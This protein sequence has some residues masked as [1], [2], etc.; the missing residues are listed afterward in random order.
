MAD[1]KKINGHSLKDEEARNLLASKSNIGHI[2][3]ER[4]AIKEVEENVVLLVTN[5]DA[6]QYDIDNHNHNKLYA[7]KTE[8]NNTKVDVESLFV[9]IEELTARV[10]NLESIIN[11]QEPETPEDPE[12]EEPDNTKYVL[13]YKIDIGESQKNISEDLG[14]Y[15]PQL[16][17]EGAERY[18]LEGELTFVLTDGTT[19]TNRNIAPSRVSKVRITYGSYIIGIKFEDVKLTELIDIDTSNFTTLNSMFANCDLVQS[20][21]LDYWD[22]SKV[23]D[24]QNMFKG[25]TRL[26]ILNMGSWD[27]SKIENA[28]GMLE[29]LS[30]LDFD[31]YGDNYSKFYLTEEETDY[32]GTF[33][34]NEEQ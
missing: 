30:D 11:N 19:T 20:L 32:T 24:V 18:P 4:Y 2:H 7:N 3:D 12:P 10:Q 34:W 9:L 6:M 25:C 16:V 21:D 14:L 28:E 8:F 27:T 5:M 13:E 15:L 31:Y 17:T 23:T 33:P 1:I 22:I 26:M 29:G